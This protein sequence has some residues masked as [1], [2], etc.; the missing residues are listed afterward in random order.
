M[1]RCCACRHTSSSFE[2]FTHLSLTLP[3]R[4]SDGDDDER[5]QTE[6]RP[7]RAAHAHTHTRAHPTVACTLTPGLP[8]PPRVAPRALQAAIALSLGDEPAPRTRVQQLLHDCFSS[9]VRELRCAECGHE[10]AVATIFPLKP[11]RHLLLHLKRFDTDPTSGRTHKRLT[12]VVIDE[13]VHLRFP[14]ATPYAAVA[15]D[16]SRYDLRSLVMHHGQDST[17]GHYTA[18]AQL[19]DGAWAHYDDERVEVVGRTPFARLEAER[20]G[21]L[22]LYELHE[23]MQE[24]VVD[25]T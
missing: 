25:V 13:S 17:S 10:R 12:R 8:H 7:R 23:A 22:L 3:L 4:H 2:R 20:A 21:Y 19:D 9:E 11:P 24:S 16:G 5:A 18:L 1:L 15:P 6:V 14:P